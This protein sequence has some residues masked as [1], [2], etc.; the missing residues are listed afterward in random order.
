MNRPNLYKEK[1]KS[2]FFWRVE[3]YLANNGE[4][5]IDGDFTSEDGDY[6]LSLIRYMEEKHKT[7]NKFDT[8]TIYINSYGGDLVSGLNLYEAL[9]HTELE[10]ET[11]I[12]GYACSIAGIL[13]LAGDE[14]LMLPHSH[15]HMHEPRNAGR[16]AGTMEELEYTLK[17]LNKYK[18]V[19]TNIIETR[20]DLD[21]DEISYMITNRD[22]FFSAEEA[23][24]KGIATGIVYKL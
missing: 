14:I 6:I 21:Y 3:D 1:A 24:Q 8:V 19:I 23:L 20:T 11:V 2:E 4:I 17:D 18:E 13:F 22:Q 7:N 10:V 16:P 12:T 15:F 9:R 5:W